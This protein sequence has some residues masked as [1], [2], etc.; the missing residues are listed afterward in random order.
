MLHKNLLKSHVL[1]RR[2][3]FKVMFDEVAPGFYESLYKRDLSEF[4]HNGFASVMFRV[5]YI[6]SES[7]RTTMG[8]EFSEDFCS[9]ATNQLVVIIYGI[10]NWIP[11]YFPK[12][13]ELVHKDTESKCKEALTWLKE[14]MDQHITMKPVSK[15]YY[16]IVNP[17]IMK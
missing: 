2:V 15:S 16:E 14:S 13:T 11:N 1:E 17:L 12:Y 3:K 5:N 8:S 10:L 7:G 9:Y 6:S 4:A